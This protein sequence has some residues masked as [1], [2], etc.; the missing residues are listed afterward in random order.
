[1]SN[2]FEKTSEL[3]LR[4][5]GQLLIPLNLDVE[6]NVCRKFEVVNRHYLAGHLDDRPSNAVR[7]E[8]RGVSARWCLY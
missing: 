4:I 6:N 7:G 2:I 3:A 5:P 8:P 1:M